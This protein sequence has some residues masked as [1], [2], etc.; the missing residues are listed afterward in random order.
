MTLEGLCITL[1]VIALV[2]GIGGAWQR[3]TRTTPACRSCRFDLRGS[4]LEHKTCPECGSPLDREGAAYYPQ[5]WAKPRLAR[6]AILCLMLGVTGLVVTSHHRFDL[7]WDIHQHKP[8]GL[9]HW[10][11]TRSNQTTAIPAVEELTRRI[12]AG[13]VARAD[14]IDL[15][16]RALA[17][18]ADPQH[19]WTGAWGDLI[20]EAA[21]AGIATREQ[22]ATYVEQGL[23]LAVPAS[24]VVLASDYHD[25]EAHGQV[26]RLGTAQSYVVRLRLDTITL[27]END[28]DFTIAAFNRLT[29]SAQSDFRLN[30]DLHWNA[31]PRAPSP[32]TYHFHSSVNRADTAGPAFTGTHRLHAELEILS[33][34]TVRNMLTEDRRL[35]DQIREALSVRT[36]RH[37]VSESQE[38]LRV[39]IRTDG[40]PLPITFELIS[41]YDGG[42]LPMRRLRLPN[43]RSKA[44]TIDLPIER[45][46]PKQPLTVVLRPVGA[47]DDSLD[48]TFRSIVAGRN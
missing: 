7:G 36:P 46:V 6:C 37:D 14:E 25:F 8:I 20:E 30:Q 1:V 45:F 38:V 18:Q 15:I 4:G 35:L 32:V 40:L 10:Q 19:Q 22:V 9:L 43:G 42:H 11:A 47:D 33:Y 34:E 23:V 21:A 12:V 5:T 39:L 44:R 31:D 27:G 13:E 24:R 28:V 26:E 41:H 29:T 48:I 3:T 16:D 17:F 2:I